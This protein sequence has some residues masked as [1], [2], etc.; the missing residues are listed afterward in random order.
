T[1][2]MSIG[3]K[4]VLFP[5]YDLDLVASAVKKSPPTFLPAVP[6]IYDQL[7]R[8]A[9]RGTLDLSTVRFAISGAMSLHVS[10]VERFL[11]I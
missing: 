8:A 7:A 11:G 1:F 2:A 9:A 3:A 10:S 5:K 4:L 6:P